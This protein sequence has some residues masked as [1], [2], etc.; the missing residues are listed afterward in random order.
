MELGQ[1]VCVGYQN[2]GRIPT[3]SIESVGVLLRFTFDK[4]RRRR[5]FFGRAEQEDRDVLPNLL[6]RL[7]GQWN[8]QL[9]THTRG[10]HPP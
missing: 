2:V 7:Y 9:W 4:S 10:R 5:S 8:P 6:H 1:W 3:G